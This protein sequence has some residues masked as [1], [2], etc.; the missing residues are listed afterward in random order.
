MYQK[1]PEFRL[2]ANDSTKIW[3]YLGFTKLVSLVA[4]KTLFF[5][6][7]DKLTDRFEGSYSKATIESRRVSNIPEE[8]QKEYALHHKQLRKFTY[9]NSWHMSEHESEAMWRLF[10]KN[11]EEGVA[12]QSTLK[13]LH[14][15][16]INYPEDVYIGQVDYV[17]YQSHLIPED[18]LF[19]SFLHKR[20]SFEHE[21]EVRALI[22]K[23]PKEEQAQ[24]RAY[25]SGIYVPIAIDALI[26]K[27]YVSPFSTKSF[28]D[29]V[30][31][32]CEEYKIPKVV[33]QS[34]LSEDPI[35]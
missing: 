8:K 12:L 23:V 27:V 29:L 26:E 35:Y 31:S 2:P 3:R 33:V 30:Y 1:H 34:D 9:I 17:D 25:D 18:K 5:S 21:K 24:K 6:R 11:E 15:C 32:V 7:V 20:K 4:T 13:S 14:E 10:T 28:H 16:F 19:R 22:S